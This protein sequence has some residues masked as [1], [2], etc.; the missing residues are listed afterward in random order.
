MRNA[1]P[2]SWKVPCENCPLRGKAITNQ[3]PKVI[4]GVRF[5][6][7]IEVIEVPANHAA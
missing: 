7:G 1:E 2:A 5:Q 4:R 6:D 3:L